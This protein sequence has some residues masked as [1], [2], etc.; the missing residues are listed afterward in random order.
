MAGSKAQNAPRASIGDL[1]EARERRIQK[2]LGI[3]AAALREFS[4]DML[5][6]AHQE[7]LRS[8]A[9]GLSEITKAELERRGLPVD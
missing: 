5:I 2:V 7:N 9:D 8:N 1:H 4:H 6:A 3:Y